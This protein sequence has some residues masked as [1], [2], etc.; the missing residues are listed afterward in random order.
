MKI[1]HLIDSLRSGGKERQ[2]VEVLKFFSQQEK[3]TS[4]LVVM[5]DENHYTYIENLNIKTYKII[6]KMKKD[7]SVFFKF[8]KIFK[9]SKPDIVHSWC[10]MSSVYSLPAAKIIGIKFPTFWF[11]IY[12]QKKK[13]II[14]FII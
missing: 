2:L 13:T 4:N 3:I 5:S 12:I 6:R 7:F 8:Y 1:I 9:D 14:I 11:N 10:S